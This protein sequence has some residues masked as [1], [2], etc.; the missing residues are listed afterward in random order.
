MIP[1]SYSQSFNQVGSGMVP[2]FIDELT[3]TFV[4][5]DVH[6][7][8][9]RIFVIDISV[10]EVVVFNHK[11]QFLQRFG[12]GTLESPWAITSDTS[13]IYISDLNRNSLMIFDLEGN[14]VDELDDVGAT[15]YEFL[16]ID[17]IEVTNTSIFTVDEA[18]GRV[19]IFDK[20]LNYV[21]DVG[22]SSTFIVPIGITTV[23]N[24][25]LIAD[26]AGLIH[27]FDLATLNYLNQVYEFQGTNF[28]NL[29]DLASDDH[30]IYVTDH[31]RGEIIVFSHDFLPVHKYSTAFPG[32]GTFFGPVGIDAHDGLFV[33]SDN[34]LGITAVY[35]NGI[36]QNLVANPGI[37]NIALAWD[38]PLSINRSD[39]DHFRIYRSTNLSLGFHYY[40]DSYE[41]FFFDESVVPGVEYHY[42][43]TVT[44][45]NRE[46]FES[47]L[48]STIITGEGIEGVIFGNDE[49]N[50]GGLPISFWIF[51]SSFVVLIALKRSKKE[52]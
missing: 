34:L 39:F 36:P 15:N 13:R 4:P 31:G 23:G 30:Y 32:S 28:T 19:M 48:A 42:K 5:A 8:D 35:H 17:R 50:D 11:M 24:R 3:S 18:T 49:S 29:S 38:Y 22:D 25:L 37:T 21:G 16:T 6:I 41:P 26:F 40:A 43:V 12:A 52:H 27:V 2:I 45:G 7:T 9:D 47:N 44:D 33:V 10:N 20:S 1:V 46:S 14:F 51:I